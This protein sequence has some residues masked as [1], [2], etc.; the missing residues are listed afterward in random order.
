MGGPM[1]GGEIMGRKRAN[2][3]VKNNFI[4][5]SLVD[6]VDIVRYITRDIAVISVAVRIQKSVFRLTGKVSFRTLRKKINFHKGAKHKLLNRL[7]ATV[8][9]RQTSLT[10]KYFKHK[11]DMII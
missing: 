3:C 2:L 10:L 7:L 11:H 1:L 6:D 5:I 4:L 8:V 9:C